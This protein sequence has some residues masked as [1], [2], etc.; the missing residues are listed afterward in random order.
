[1][2][3]IPN[4]ITGSRILLSL[5]LPA[6]PPMTPL[7]Y[8]LYVVTGI[9]DIADGYLARKLGAASAQGAILDSIA[10]AVF[11]VAMVLVSVPWLMRIAWIFWWIGA[12]AFI[13][14]AALL[15]GFFKYRTAAFLHTYGNKAAGLALYLLPFFYGAS[16]LDYAAAAACV[17]AAAAALEELVIQ[18]AS[19]ELD[20]DVRGLFRRK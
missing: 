2:K 6:L 17:I 10:D 13:R 16:F 14:V 9:S 1:M 7:F 20:R 5:V 19:K 3:R 8:F 11:V 15:I 18:A 4:L 12:V